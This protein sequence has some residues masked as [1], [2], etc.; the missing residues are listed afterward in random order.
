[1]KFYKL[2]NILNEQKLEDVKVHCGKMKKALNIDDDKQ[3]SDVYTSGKK[4]AKD[5][6]NKVGLKKAQGMLAFAANIHKEQ[7]IF[8]VALRNL[9]TNEQVELNEQ[10]TVDSLKDQLD[11]LKKKIRDIGNNADPKQKSIWNKTLQLLQQKI[12]LAQKSDNIKQEQE[13]LNKQKGLED[14]D[15]SNPSDSSQ[16]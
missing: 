10:D 13:R 4:L 2:Y 15:Q 7:D 16:E 3:V 1:M 5:L 8:D 11:T 9:P 14:K 12:G 6:V